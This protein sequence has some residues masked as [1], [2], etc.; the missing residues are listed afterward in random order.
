MT[1]LVNVWDVLLELS[2]WLLL[3]AAVSGAL[4]YLVPSGFIKSQLSGGWGVAKAVVLGVPLPLCSCGVIPAGIGLK[5]NG[6][7]DGASVGFLVATPQTG[8]DSVLVSAGML[9]WPFAL[10][11]VGAALVTGLVAGWTTDA[12]TPRGVSKIEADDAHEHVHT[13]SDALHH[14]IDV[15]R[16]VW[17]WLAFGVLFSAALTT[18]LPVDAFAGLTGGATALAFGAVLG[19]SLPLYVCAT[20]S[21]PIAAALVAAGMPTG[22]ALV[23][24]MAGPATN[25]ATLGTVYRT[26]GR[27]VLGVY[28]ATILAG[29]IGFGLLYEQVF[30]SLTATVAAAH[31]HTTWWSIASAVVLLGLLARFAYDDAMLWF[32]NRTAVSD[33]E[34]ALTIEVQGMTCEGCANKV[35][36]ALL[37]TDGVQSA[38]INLDANTA[39][40]SGNAALSRLQQS[41]TDAGFHISRSE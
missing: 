34:R 31:A 30:G 24:L 36:R 21:V 18:A 41:I 35:Q 1:F 25:V 22:A 10:W 39:V 2:P 26:F 11:K 14:A 13:L 4:H 16:E 8:V 40:I 17:G 20:A 12:I 38:V 7:S 33:D 27:N 23:F 3:G 6:A 29:S 28:L 37:A 32:A 9:G 5:R 19:I 15:I